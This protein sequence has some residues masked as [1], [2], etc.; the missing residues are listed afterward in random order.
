[1]PPYTI[2][3]LIFIASKIILKKG[4]QEKKIKKM[5]L[6]H[7][8]FKKILIFLNIYG[9]LCPFSANSAI[10]GWLS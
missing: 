7:N 1:M 3:F 8:F 5:F 10:C 2:S 9:L 4:L 6:V